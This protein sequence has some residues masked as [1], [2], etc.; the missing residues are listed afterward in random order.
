MNDSENILMTQLNRIEV[1][2]DALTG[3]LN[4]VSD[5]LSRLEAKV[6]AQDNVNKKV[7]ELWAMKNQGVGIKTIFAWL[8]PLVL[9]LYGIC[10]K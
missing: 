8:I 1:K 2:M 4:K 5:R 9:S 6:E 10:I 7:D 3:S